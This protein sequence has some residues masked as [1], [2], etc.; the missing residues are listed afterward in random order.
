MSREELLRW[1][2][3]RLGVADRAPARI[4]ARG[5]D[6]DDDDDSGESRASGDDDSQDQ[7]DDTFMNFVNTGG[8]WAS[9]VAAPVPGP[10]NDDDGD[11]F[12]GSEDDAP[13]R[14][15]FDAVDL[16][17]WV[18]YYLAKEGM[19]QHPLGPG[20]TSAFDR[21]PGAPR[22]A[23]P[24]QRIV[25]WDNTGARGEYERG[26]LLQLGAYR[27]VTDGPVD[28]SITLRMLDMLLGWVT[29]GDVTEYAEVLREAC[30]LHGDVKG[31]LRAYVAECIRKGVSPVDALIDQNALAYRRTVDAPVDVREV[32]AT[33]E[34]PE[35]RNTTHDAI[36]ASIG[37]AAARLHANALMYPGQTV[38]VT[39]M[40]RYTPDMENDNADDGDDPFAYFPDDGLLL[41]VEW[42]RLMKTDLGGVRQLHV[43]TEDMYAD[44]NRAYQLLGR[45]MPKVRRLAVSYR[46][47]DSDDFSE[48][49]S[50]RVFSRLISTFPDLESLAI[51]A[52][53][54]GSRL[55]ANLEDTLAVC[56]A[57][58]RLTEVVVVGGDV[59]VMADS[60]TIGDVPL[61]A[62][63]QGV[64]VITVPQND[65]DEPL[66]RNMCKLIQRVFAKDSATQ[67][68]VL[69][70]GHV[71]LGFEDLAKAVAEA[72]HGTLL[73]HIG[74]DTEALMAPP[75]LDDEI[76]E[77]L[78]F[79]DPDAIIM[80]ES[81][82]ADDNRLEFGDDEDID[83]NGRVQLYRLVLAMCRALIA[84]GNAIEFVAPNNLGEF[85]ISG[86]AS[87]L[88]EYWQERIVEDPSAAGI[89]RPYINVVGRLVRIVVKPYAVGMTTE[90]AEMER[91]D[92]LDYAAAQEYVDC[93]VHDRASDAAARCIEGAR[94]ALKNA[95]PRAAA[96]VGPFF[97]WARHLSGAVRARYLGDCV[98]HLLVTYRERI[99]VRDAQALVR[100]FVD[101]VG[102]EY[103]AEYARRVIPGLARLDQVFTNERQDA[104]ENAAR[105]LGNV[106]PAAGD[107]D[108]NAWVRLEFGDGSEVR[109]PRQVAMRS[110]TLRNVL[111]GNDD[112]DNTDAPIIPIHAYG[113]DAV[114][115]ALGVETIPADGP[116]AL[117]DDALAA[118]N[119]LDAD[120]AIADIAAGFVVSFAR[121]P[122]MGIRD[123]PTNPEIVEIDDNGGDDGGVVVINDVSQR[124]KRGRPSLSV[125][126]IDLM[127][128]ESGGES[129]DDE[130]NDNW[131]Q[132][133]KRTQAEPDVLLL[134]SD[135]E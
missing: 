113:R 8:Q 127:D 91:P 9:A 57:H 54:P 134:D 58:P 130:D 78:E 84:G 2:F 107:G 63:Q 16:W 5:D 97:R 17:Q 80:P 67:L 32:Y 95:N 110:G 125:P 47:T 119:F 1:A 64:I 73:V 76:E 46:V 122:D 51:G 29:P 38:V 12:L 35:G 65:D 56:A 45:C 43:Y 116:P 89:L 82:W 109:I 27:L 98:R 93:A 7:Q 4:A 81:W 114:L 55:Y 77:P 48:G 59:E 37:R 28:L 94:R 30:R 96:M 74:A 129:S 21:V 13:R 131:R 87:Q 69:H 99:N 117:L 22:I 61:A 40:P 133:G 102:R 24:R 72:H 49:M 68:L 115:V 108:V 126:L 121:D 118:A 123:R 34:Y 3:E 75:P 33:I 20:V 124:P 44:I 19:L 25:V 15:D 101:F 66:S 10:R 62:P 42:L 53:T 52:T 41:F 79:F 71:F 100:Q 83:Y 14:V 132:S 112:D 90:E 23:N 50:V 6:D 135:D 86:A 39:F 18:L 104:F 11:V 128:T 70:T 26:V 111:E 88:L 103:E 60:D 105:K 120:V 106:P 85:R 92:G 31:A 36:R